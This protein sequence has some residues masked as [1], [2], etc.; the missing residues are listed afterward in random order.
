MFLYASLSFHTHKTESWVEFLIIR[1]DVKRSTVVKSSVLWDYSR[2]CELFLMSQHVWNNSVM[3]VFRFTV[4]D[5]RF[6]LFGYFFFRCVEL[7]QIVVNAANCNKSG[8]SNRLRC[9]CLV[10]R[11]FWFEK[12]NIYIVTV[13]FENTSRHCLVN[14]FLF[15]RDWQSRPSSFESWLFEIILIFIVAGFYDIWVMF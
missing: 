3:F 15:R 1:H 13:I 2:Y 14:N 8:R 6:F 5:F 12:K 4:K 11:I 7:L 9:S 10:W